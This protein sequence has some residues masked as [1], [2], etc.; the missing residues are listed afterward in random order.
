MFCANCGEV[1]PD[2]A[3]SC[4][5][6]GVVIPPF[7]TVAGQPIDLRDYFGMAV[8]SSFFFLPLGVAA[9]FYSRAVGRRIAGA[10]LAGAQRASRTVLWLAFSAIVIGFFGFVVLVRMLCDN[11]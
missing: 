4:A 6:C 8:F 9:L 5:K 3:P 11:W 2:G 1:H 10:D 7:R